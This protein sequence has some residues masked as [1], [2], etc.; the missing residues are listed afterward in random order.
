M[1]SQR[2]AHLNRWTDLKNLV[3]DRKYFRNPLVLGVLG[4]AI[5]AAALG[6]KAFL[7]PAAWDL[8]TDDGSPLCTVRRGWMPAQVVRACGQP[9]ATGM[10]PKVGNT[11]P[12]MFCSSPCELYGQTLV[13]YDC[14]GK[15][16]DSQPLSGK[17]RCSAQ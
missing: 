9:K 16:Y 4:V 17:W 13:L 14:D 3:G 5:V 15:V 7:W 6:A 12:Q 10:Q 2:A 11:G 1:G 8:R